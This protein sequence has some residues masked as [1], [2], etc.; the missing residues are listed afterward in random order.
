MLAVVAGTCAVLLDLR[1]A[2]LLEQAAASQN[3]QGCLR[4]WQPQAP[5]PC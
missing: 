3:K 1:Q 5:L 4:L 2:A